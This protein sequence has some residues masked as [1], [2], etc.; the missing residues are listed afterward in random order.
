MI[1]RSPAEPCDI[2]APNALG[3]ILNPETIA[4]LR[5]KIVCGAANNRLLDQQR[6]APFCERGIAF[7]PSTSPPTAWAS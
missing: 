3:G 6:D 4:R 5:A 2:L 7:V 1:R